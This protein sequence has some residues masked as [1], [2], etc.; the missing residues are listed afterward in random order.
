[1]AI[2]KNELVK[3]AQKDYEYLTGDAATRRLQE[4]REKAILDENSAYETGVKRGKKEGERIGEV[5]GRKL[6][7]AH[8]KAIGE[9]NGLK[10]G[11]IEIAKNMIKNNIKR[12]MISKCT[13][14]SE[15]ELEKL[16]A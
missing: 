10:R 4:L 3:K 15:K 14:L 5:R 9:K 7:E 12:E 11:Q 16:F 13:G 1:M 8:G 6:G 2:E